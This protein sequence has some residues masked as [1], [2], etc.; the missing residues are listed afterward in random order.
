MFISFYTIIYFFVKKIYFVICLYFSE[1]DIRMS[2]YVF[3]LAK[4]P[5]IRYVRNWSGDE[6]S[7]KMRADVY[8]RRAC[9]TL[10]VRAHLHAF[11]SI[12]VLQW[13]ILFVE[14]QPYLIQK[15]CGRQKRLFFS[16]KINFCRQLF[17]LKIVFGNQI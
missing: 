5:S 7:Y 14:I 12:F 15:R 10:C 13:L 9:H 4:R 6:V 8:R 17:L 11:G 16:S 3:W 1:Y 2:L